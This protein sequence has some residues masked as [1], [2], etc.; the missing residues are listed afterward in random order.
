VPAVV[1]GALAG[2]A[3]IPGRNA[4]YAE[5]CGSMSEQS[6]S[7]DFSIGSPITVYDAVMALKTTLDTPRLSGQKEALST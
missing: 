2:A 6:S 4:A 5:N 1:E 7:D 3:L